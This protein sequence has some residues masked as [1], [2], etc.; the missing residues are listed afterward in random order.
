[1][2]QIQINEEHPLFQVTDTAEPELESFN[3]E[4]SVKNGSYQ[5]KRKKQKKATI[6]LKKSQLQKHF[7]CQMCYE[8]FTSIIALNRHKK[9]HPLD[10]QFKCTTCSESFNIHE[11]LELHKIIHDESIKSCP[12]CGIAFKRLASLHGHIKIHFKTEVFTCNQCEEIFT[13]LLLL[14]THTDQ[15]HSKENLNIQSRST[16]LTKLKKSTK[17]T[18]KCTHCAKIFY[19]P[20]HLIRHLRIH[21]GERPFHCEICRDKFGQKTTLNIH[22]LRHSGSKPHSCPEC[23]I[24]FSQKGN[25]KTHLKRVHSN[26]NQKDNEQYPC[27]L[28]SCVFRKL[29]TLN[30]HIT[31]QHSKIRNDNCL[32]DDQQPKQSD[33]DKIFKQIASLKTNVEEKAEKKSTISLADNTN[34]EIVHHNVEEVITDGMFEFIYVFFYSIIVNSFL[35]EI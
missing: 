4:S 9:S 26:F 34:G 2:E 6:K 3:Q 27:N 5:L 30:R 35:Y 24:K 8:Q 19:K 31:E 29:G 18:L 25:L 33:F 14:K 1:M 15:Y 11:N 23:F 32:D 21:N 10:R 20:S 16:N 7:T 28:C 22:M 13:T 12:Q 17:Q